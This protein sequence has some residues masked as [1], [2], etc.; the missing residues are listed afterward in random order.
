MEAGS[1]ELEG[2]SIETMEPF[3][4]QSSREGI[5]L[6]WCRKFHVIYSRRLYLTPHVYTNM[7][8]QFWEI[9]YTADI[10]VPLKSICYPN[11]LSQDSDAKI[12]QGH[13]KKPLLTATSHAIHC[14][15]S[16]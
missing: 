15:N 14:R 8:H 13:T 4:S 9:F 2:W 6:I 11:E 16:V 12:K 3:P 7:I 1:L 5:C 10:L